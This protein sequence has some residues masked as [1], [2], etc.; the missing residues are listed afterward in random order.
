LLSI[1]VYEAKFK[2][3]LVVPISKKFK[4]VAEI[5]YTYNEL[6]LLGK[7]EMKSY[8]TGEKEIRTYE[9]QIETL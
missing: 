3:E 8:I 1:T 9:Y 5:K 2:G 6:G 7:E 4:K